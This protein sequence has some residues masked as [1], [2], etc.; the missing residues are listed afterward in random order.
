MH[1]A[2]KEGS[3]FI[4]FANLQLKSKCIISPSLTMN[5]KA[6]HKTNL[7]MYVQLC[8][9]MFSKHDLILLSSL[10]AANSLRTN[11]TQRNFTYIKYVTCNVT[12]RARS[13]DDKLDL[14]EAS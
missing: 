13:V 8:S 5:S 9:V 11:V 10:F 2:Q 6:S 12:R 4:I 3:E 14:F 7:E 1:I